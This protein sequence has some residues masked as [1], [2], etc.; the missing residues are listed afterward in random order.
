M[1]EAECLFR[2]VSVCHWGGPS[3]GSLSRHYAGSRPRKAPLFFLCIDS[4]MG[5]VRGVK[6]AFPSSCI[7]G[8]AL[9]RSLLDAPC[10][11]DRRSLPLCEGISCES[12]CETDRGADPDLRSPT[13]TT[14]S[15]SS[16]GCSQKRLSHGLAQCDSPSP[17]TPHVCSSFLRA[18][19][20]IQAC[21][22]PNV[23]CGTRHVTLSGKR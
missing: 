13:P 22:G 6:L 1:V 5:E 7:W 19:L 20:K 23:A 8:Q 12:N 17:G 2:G 4:S 18:P 16:F 9:R 21:S 11:A 14:A 15:P 3:R 10:P